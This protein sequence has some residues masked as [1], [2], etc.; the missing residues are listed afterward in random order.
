[1]QHNDLR[2][3]SNCVG[4]PLGSQQ[5]AHFRQVPGCT[6]A[7]HWHT[8]LLITTAHQ[9][10]A[11]RFRER[12]MHPVHAGPAGAE[13]GQGHAP[14][15][16]ETPSPSA[17]RAGLIAVDH[18]P[19]CAAPH[20]PAR[21]RQRSCLVNT[22]TAAGASQRGWPGGRAR[23]GAGDEVR[24]ADDDAAAAARSACRMHASQPVPRLPGVPASAAV[25]TTASQQAAPLT[26][27]QGYAFWGPTP[28]AERTAAAQRPPG[29]TGAAKAAGARGCKPTIP[30]ISNHHTISRMQLFRMLQTPPISP[31]V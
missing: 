27:V 20:P 18:G 23:R 22:R 21:E 13:E 25:S 7:T 6:L 9:R 8:H 11:A 14:Q 16:R 2:C 15:R 24:D 19:E 28:V 29:P 17:C 4:V 10:T 5:V 1:M 31:Q 30:T 12:P 3:K 26:A